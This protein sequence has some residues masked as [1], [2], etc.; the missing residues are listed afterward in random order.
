MLTPVS[1]QKTES[2]HISKIPFGFHTKKARSFL[3]VA[4][5]PETIEF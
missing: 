5:R 2:M 3:V 4:S 1:C